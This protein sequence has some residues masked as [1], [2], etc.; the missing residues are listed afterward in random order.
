MATIYRANGTK[1]EVT[2]KNG[3]DFKLKELQKIVGGVIDIIGLD[4]GKI[5]VINDEGKLMYLPIN[6]EATE[7]YQSFY[8]TDDFIVGDVLVCEDEEVQ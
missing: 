7:M 1:E 5:M 6:M 2:P 4:N 8:N 3:M